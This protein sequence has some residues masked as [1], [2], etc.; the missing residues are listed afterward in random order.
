MADRI[1]PY[2]MNP[3]QNFIP[4]QHMQQ[5]SQQQQQQQQQ[6][7]DSQ[8][9]P[10]LPNPE[11]S[12]MWTQIQN[13][14]RAQPNGDANSAQMNS[15]M[16]DLAR[17]QGLSHVH[18]QGPLVQQI[19]QQ[20]GLA[21]AQRVPPSASSFHDPQSSNTPSSIIP[22]NF[23]S[24]PMNTP[25]M[26]PGNPI[27]ALAS[28]PLH[29][30]D[31]P[32]NQQNQHPPQ[33]AMPHHIQQQMGTQ[34]GSSPPNSS[35]M[36][37]SSNMTHVDAM[38]SSPHL[39]AQP[40]GGQM[41]HPNMRAPQTSKVPTLAELM[42]RREYL[43]AAITSF[44]QN[45]QNVLAQTGGFPDEVWTA[46]LEKMRTELQNRKTLFLRVNQAIQLASNTPGML[47]GNLAHLGTM[48]S[49]AGRPGVTQGGGAPQQ[50]WSQSSSPAP[51]FG[52]NP[53]ASG[54]SQIPTPG[55]AHPMNSQLSG[56]GGQMQRPGAV[57]PRSGHTP[58]QP[59]TGI[60]NT[61]SQNTGP[62]LNAQSV[63]NAQIPNRMVNLSTLGV[64]YLDKPYFEAMYTSFCKNHHVEPNMH[65]LLPDNRSVD[66][67]SLHVQVFREGGA[68]FVTQR[69]YWA[70]IGGRMGLVQFPGT[71][72][73]P[74]KSGPGIAQQLAH[75][76]KEHLQAF[77]TMLVISVR[78]R[79]AQK[80]NLS[81]NGAQ[82]NAPGSTSGEMAHSV[83]R[84]PLN[85]QAMASAVRFVN[86]SVSEMRASGLPEQ[87]VVLIDRHR[88]DIVRWHRLIAT[89]PS[90]QATNH[91]GPS[92]QSN[93]SAA[94]QGGFPNQVSTAGPGLVP[95]PRGQPLMIPNGMQSSPMTEM[96][97]I[98]SGG[99]LPPSQEQI[100]HAMSVIQYMKQ[101]FSSRGLQA[102]PLLTVPDD[103][104]ME[105]NQL[106]DQVQK[107]TRDLDTRL[108][109]YWIVLRSEDMIRRL[110]AIVL[111]VAH[112]RNRFPVGSPQV[113]IGVHTLKSMYSQVQKANEEFE[114]RCQ[115]M[116]AVL[117]S[118]QTGGHSGPHI[119]RPPPPPPPS[120]PTSSQT[121]QPPPTISRHPS[122]NQSH[123]PSHPQPSQPMVKKPPV[124]VPPNPS[125]PVAITTT[126]AVP[127]PTPPP[128][129]TTS[130]A[131]TPLAATSPQTPKSPKSKQ[132]PKGK[133][134]RIPKQPTASPS[135]TP[136][137]FSPGVKRQADE[138]VPIPAGPSTQPESM[139][140]PSP[141]KVK[142]E[143]W[144]GE[145]SEELAKRHQE[146]EN[147]N[148]DEDANAFMD[149]MKELVAMTAS[150][151]A[152]VYDDIAHT[153]DRILQ[154]TA[155]DPTH[156]TTSA[157]ASS[158]GGPPSEL[159]PPAAP[160]DAFLEFHEFIDY[161]RFTTLEDE[162]D[163]KA[164][165][166]DLVPSSSTNPSPQ[167]NPD[168]DQSQGASSPGKAKIEDPR[169]SNQLDLLHMGAF[170]EIDGGES[171]YYQS[172]DW[173]WDG[174]M[175]TLDQPWAI[176]QTS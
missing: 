128:A 95:A 15:Q 167:S 138:D 25:Q 124:R 104:R 36:F 6:Q 74:A 93:M 133:V 119:N 35:D 46:K 47:G 132:P 149:K 106:M 44:E 108:P 45:I 148:T 102:M 13:N 28:R 14:Y 136:A 172:S 70:I 18:S 117:A 120:Q 111:T 170:K 134:Q 169:E 175:T 122:S 24:M 49:T 176:Y 140:A 96:K 173:K 153:L 42:Q 48:A 156:I 99:I 12:R 76:Y 98:Q 135:E 1:P 8:M 61:M 77:E 68:Q 154:G 85:P 26:K 151:D 126:N 11:H 71:D 73:E 32:S 163:S 66:L 23:S 152:G 64:S 123:P 157:F 159:S 22:P 147:I 142:T 52:M 139:G 103:Q 101:L 88:S 166:P 16:A 37:S 150:T 39:A 20:F 38:H 69:D 137:A 80:N 56:Q 81:Q 82:N 75:A 121:L 171:A 4:Q 86:M 114:Q 146:V 155:Q 145:P 165:T 162:E 84:P 110:V 78:S 116:K 129:T 107:M 27:Q 17:N 53:G 50:P 67:H 54:P 33:S 160:N 164:P 72:T 5:Q 168:A 62:Q 30:M 9:V 118:Q 59:P 57:P 83:M 55:Q 131:P 19:Q 89:K 90:Q 3:L 144:E 91:E 105:Y 161:S 141:K 97:P 109:M 112:Q 41:G 10:G 130:T 43:Q 100:A 143:D 40:L 87:T 79:A 7:P 2:Q 58:Q 31:R 94:H 158:I 29:L 65:V 60:P 113:I 63:A 21:S 125:V 51:N 174:P 92:E 127:S 34:P 115:I